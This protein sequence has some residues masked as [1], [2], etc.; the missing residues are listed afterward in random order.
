MR[1]LR[2][3]RRRDV[4]QH[5]ALQRD[6]IGVHR[7]GD[8]VLV[9]HAV[10][11]TALGLREDLQ[12]GELLH[13][14]EGHLQFDSIELGLT[15]AAMIRRVDPGG[16]MSGCLAH[17]FGHPVAPLFLLS[18]RAVDQLREVDRDDDVGRPGRRCAVVANVARAASQHESTTRAINSRVPRHV[19]IVDSRQRV[20]RLRFTTAGPRILR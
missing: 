3:L 15:S 16:I 10:D 6:E 4:G 1:D 9:P 12:R 18:E 14:D 8:G 13:L 20:G 5:V 11:V 19:F 17:D 7:R 2:A